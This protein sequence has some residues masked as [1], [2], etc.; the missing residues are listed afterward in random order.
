LLENWRR[1]DID[2]TFLDEQKA[3]IKSLEK[4]KKQIFLNMQ[5][6][7]RLKR[8]SLWLQVRDENTKF[9][10]HCSNGRKNRKAIWNIG[11]EDGSLASSFGDIAFKGVS[12]F[13]SLCKEY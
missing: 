4:E 11:K 9:F 10:H 6:A 2:S 3:H 7:S 5:K 1:M 13:K 8:R 12:F